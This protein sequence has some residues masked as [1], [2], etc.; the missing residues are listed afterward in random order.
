MPSV[1]EKQQ[2]HDNIF[3]AASDND[4]SSVLQ[5]LNSGVDVNQLDTNGY[6]TLHAASSYNHFELLDTL[7]SHGGNVNL[8]DH[9]GD[10]PIFVAETREMCAA[11]IK[12]GA[13]LNHRNHVGLTVLEHV[14]EADEFPDL[15]AYLQSISDNPSKQVPHVQARYEQQSA[16]SNGQQSDAPDLDIPGLSEDVKNCIADVMQ[17]SA[18]DGVD[19]DDELRTILSDA[20]VGQGVLDNA[21]SRQRTD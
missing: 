2:K 21:N 1:A 14:R 8:P 15:V 13:D 18:E 3:L 20:L 10:T 11:L 4:I 9:D 19:R 7:L 16:K 5:F 6:S 12:F 17:K